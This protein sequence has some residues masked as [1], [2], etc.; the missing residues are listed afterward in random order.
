MGLLR[1]LQGR[2]K[3]GAFTDDACASTKSLCA[4]SKKKRGGVLFQ[5][6]LAPPR[7]H[8]AQCPKTPTTLIG[9][10]QSAISP[11]AR[12]LRNSVFRHRSS[13]NHH[14]LFPRVRTPPTS[15]TLDA[16]PASCF[17]LYCNSHF[18][19][20]DS[21]SSSSLKRQAGGFA[22]PKTHFLFNRFPQQA[23]RPGPPPANVAGCFQAHRRGCPDRRRHPRRRA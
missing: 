2:T 17:L 22:D 9:S 14:Q 19:R 18:F 3:E 12:F 8:V 23:S 10:E 4:V 11:S 20:D 6:S 1:P 5:M 16:R 13:T 21:F 7:N 15:P